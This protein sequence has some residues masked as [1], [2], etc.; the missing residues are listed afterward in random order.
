MFASSVTVIS[1]TLRISKFTST[2]DSS[3]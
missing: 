2:P 3:T 1:N